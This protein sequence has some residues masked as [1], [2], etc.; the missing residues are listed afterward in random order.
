MT[1]AL[2]YTMRLADWPPE[3]ADA[4]AVVLIICL[5]WMRLNLYF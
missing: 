1:V 5:A 2:V 3:M 4:Q